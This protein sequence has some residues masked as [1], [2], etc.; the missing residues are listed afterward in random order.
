MLIQKDA[1]W[2]IIKDSSEASLLED[3]LMDWS[4]EIKIVKRRNTEINEHLVKVCQHFEKHGFDTCLL[5]GQGNSLFYPIPETRIP[6]DLDIWLCFADFNRINNTQKNQK[7][8]DDIN[9]IIS[10]IR[11]YNPSAKAIYHHIECPPFKN[12]EVEVHYRP[13]YMKSFVHDRRLQRFF[14]DRKF[15]QFSHHVCFGEYKIAV[16]EEDFNVVFLLCHI[17]QHLFH[18]GIGLRQILDYYYLCISEELESK[19]LDKQYWKQQLS[20]LG[21]YKIAG[22]I[23]W[24]LVHQ[25]GMDKKYILAEPDARRGQFVFNEI[26]NGGNFGRYDERYHFSDNVWGRNLQR[27][28]RDLRLVCYFPCEALSEPFFRLYHVIWRWKHRPKIKKL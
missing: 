9:K 21:L 25:L 26:L 13:S 18:E 11:K 27:L 6:G 10:F 16:P 14:I 5:K 1:I 17:Y 4:G 8:K 3:L 22:A 28:W 2:P 15:E 12:T 23:M 7:F 19:G 20:Y 24:I